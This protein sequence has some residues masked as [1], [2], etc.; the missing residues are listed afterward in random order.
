[1]GEERKIF[2]EYD[3]EKDAKMPDQ[4]AIKD[5]VMG[6]VNKTRNVFEVISLYVGQIG[7]FI[8]ALLKTFLG[9]DKSKTNK[10]GFKD[11]NK[12]SLG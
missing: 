10:N 8:G 4:Q 11:D 1:V 2:D 12:D 3:P 6:A 7:A 5:D 9:E